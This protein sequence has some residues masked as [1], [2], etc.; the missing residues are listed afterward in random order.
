GIGQVDLFAFTLT[1]A[2]R[3]IRSAM[4]SAARDRLQ[5]IPRQPP[6]REG[7][8]NV[9]SKRFASGLHGCDRRRTL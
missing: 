6:T 2:K 1:G 7:G 5:R 3:F 4:G 8:H 9:I